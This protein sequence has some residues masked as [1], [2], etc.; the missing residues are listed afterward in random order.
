MQNAQ[1]LRILQPSRAPLFRMLLLLAA[2]IVAV[3][4]WTDRQYQGRISGGCS[5]TLSPFLKQATS[6]SPRAISFCSKQNADV[7]DLVV[8]PIR[9]G[10]LSLTVE[11]AGYGDTP[12]ISAMLVGADG[13]EVPVPLPRAGDRWVRWVIDIPPTLQDQQSRLIVRDQTQEGFGWIG[14]GIVSGYGGWIPISVAMMLLASL[15]PWLRRKVET[16]APIRAAPGGHQRT[17]IGLSIAA[18]TLLTLV[19]RR[20]SQWSHPYVWVE[21]GKY[22]LPDFLQY[23]WGTLLHPVAGYILIPNKLI[24]AISLTLSFRWLP[25]ISLM[26]TALM[27]IAVMVALAL[28]PTRLRAPWACAL[29]VLA[30]PTDAE[31]FS[32][33]AYALW[34]G[35]LLVVISLFWDERRS[36]SLRWRFPMLLIGGLS[37][38]LVVIMAPLYGVRALVLRQRNE[39]WMLLVASVIATVQAMLVV[40]HPMD[41]QE[42]RPLPGLSMLLERFVGHFL[43]WRSDLGQPTLITGLGLALLAIIVTTMW[44]QRRS[45][46]WLLLALLACF[47]LSVIA[48]AARVQVATL[49]PFNAGPRYFFYPYV[50]LAWILI[51]LALEARGPARLLLLLLLLAPLH[52]TLLYGYRTH[53]PID[54]RKEVQ[55]CT[56]ARN[57]DGPLIHT[58]GQMEHV[59]HTPLTADQCRHLVR[60]SLF[61]NMLDE[62]GLTP[63]P[64]PIPV[65]TTEKH[66]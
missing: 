56:S 23:G 36:P 8:E 29:A 19:L 62:T 26:L 38:P 9:A 10:T 57:N 32:T 58:T 50:F 59:W 64:S 17:W 20:P 6:Y 63:S 41:S 35:A 3:S 61:D 18:A 5:Q 54:W 33:S 39:W 27:T 22:L 47:F 55:K 16:A 4:G 46:G 65:S 42:H 44:A 21:D 2:V 66:Q 34:W 28:L 24:N 40:P 12:G 31:V 7:A 45:N 13:T 51:H 60:N 49:D 53:T 30:V 11:I 25:E 37:S 52:Q 15:Y 48:S 14:L 43:F 1:M